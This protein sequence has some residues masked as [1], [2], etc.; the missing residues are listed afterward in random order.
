MTAASQAA[1]DHR[2]RVPGGPMTSS[3]SRTLYEVTASKIKLAARNVPLTVTVHGVPTRSRRA[4]MAV[5]S[6]ALVVAFAGPARAVPP[7]PDQL[8]RNFQARCPELS[9]TASSMAALTEL[10]RRTQSQGNY[11]PV[12]AAAA[13]GELRTFA[14]LVRRGVQSVEL[15]PSAAGG[16]TPD[17]VIRVQ[18]EAG[19]LRDVR[20]EV[21]TVTGRSRGIQARAGSGESVASGGPARTRGIKRALRNGFRD[22]A[23]RPSQFTAPLGVNGR[24]IPPGGRL[25]INLPRG[26]RMPTAIADAMR[27]VANELREASHVREIEFIGR[28]PQ[29]PGKKPRWTTERFVRNPDGTYTRDPRG[30]A[31]DTGPRC[32]RPKGG[33]GSQNQRVPRDPRDL[34]PVAATRQAIGV[35]AAR[36]P[37]AGAGTTGGAAP[38]ASGVMA[39]TDMTTTAPGID[40][41]VGGV[42]LSSLELRYVSD[43]SSDKTRAASF[44]FKAPPKNGG[45]LGDGRNA[46]QQASE[47][48]F[49]FL[50]LDPRTFT[51]NL[52]PDQ[53]NRI[54]DEKLGRTNAGRVLLEADLRMLTCA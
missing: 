14:S 28:L 37:T 27:G 4:L 43:V 52:Q 49:V 53:P 31:A 15:V 35:A 7:P 20:V 42:D 39:T 1:C 34:D 6:L 22:T 12:Q 16:R 40:A 9:N 13:A 47:A 23:A 32:P 25:V 18:D 48:F 3:A 50:A 19:I 8:A 44:A 38:S 5:G 36:E 30:P 41:K 29:G 46:A 45:G 11:L 10:F 51:V 21:K 24:A 2:A 33:K 17:A 26:T 54:V